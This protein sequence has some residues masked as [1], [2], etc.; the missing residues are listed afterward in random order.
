ME[1]RD[2]TYQTYKA[3]LRESIRV[4]EAIK[5]QRPLKPVEA[6]NLAELYDKLDTHQ[7]YLSE[8]GQACNS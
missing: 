7:T 6:E 2:M 5:R 3:S 4:I 8:A 1:V